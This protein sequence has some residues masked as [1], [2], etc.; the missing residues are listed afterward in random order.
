MKI[1]PLDF[2]N[3]LDS[4]CLAIWFLDD[5]SKSSSVKFGVFLTVDNYSLQNINRIQE[6]F[7]NLFGF[8]TRLY[9]S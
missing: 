5:G 3:W 8:K 7:F 4:T 9:S 6:A 1:L 2:H